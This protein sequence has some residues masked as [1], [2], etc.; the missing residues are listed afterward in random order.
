M[1]QVREEAEEGEEEGRGEGRGGE[2]MRRGEGGGDGRVE[3][4]EKAHVD[5]R[6]QKQGRK[7]RTSG[8]DGRNLD[9]C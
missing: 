1:S 2:P 9:N 6:Q 7:Q 5:R 8:R 4:G 3:K